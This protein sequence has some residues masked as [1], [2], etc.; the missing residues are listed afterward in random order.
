[1]I[2]EKDFNEWSNFIRNNEVDFRYI[3]LM[4][5]GDGLD[6]FRKYHVPAK[7]FT[8]YLNKNDWIFQTLGRDA[9]PSKNYIN[10]SYKGKFGVIAPYS[11][12]FCK[13]CNRLKNNCK[14]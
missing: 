8:D 5:T 13:S 12:D 9:G 2:A 6:Y 4:Q 7:I 1:M 14:R 10:P 3:E 11:K